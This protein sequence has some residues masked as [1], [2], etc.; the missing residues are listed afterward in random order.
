M[1]RPLL[2]SAVLR[3]GGFWLHHAVG[4]LFGVGFV[5]QACILAA[6]PAC[7][8]LIGSW[9]DGSLVLAGRNVGLLQHPAIWAFFALQIGLPVS[10]RHSLK[11]LLKARSE[12]RAIVR[13][14]G[15]YWKEVVRPLLRFLHLEDRSSRFVATLVYCTGLTAFVWNTYQN[16]LPGVIVPYDFWDSKT[17]VFGFWITRVYKF[18]LFVWLLPYVALVHIGVLVVALRLIRRA[19]VAGRLQLVLFHPDGVGGLGFIPGLVTTPIIVTLLM[20]TAPTAAAFLVHRAADVTPLIGLTILVLSTAVASIIPILFLRTDI[21]LAKRHMI[22]RLRF[23]QQAYY[24]RIT[25]SRDL[26]FEA[27]RNG[28][29]ALDYFN[30]VDAAMRALSNYPHLKRVLGYMAIALTPSVISLT[31][32]LWEDF[33]PVMHLGIRK[34]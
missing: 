26:D 23:L 33:A 29:Q 4:R 9:V 3:G 15:S 31:L 11:T 7:A 10:I 34:P 5:A 25:E 12:M 32:K 16:Q 8:V 17:Y 1:R 18:Y 24:T 6:L 27:L 28:N 21:V 22:Q 30:K 13:V 20:G 2:A 14:D 19:R